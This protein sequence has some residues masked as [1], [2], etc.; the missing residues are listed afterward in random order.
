MVENNRHQ[1]LIIHLD[2]DDRPPRR[3]E[4]RV[5]VEFQLMQKLR[6]RN[7]LTETQD[8]HRFQNP[9]FLSSSHGGRTLHISK[10]FI[11][12]FF[13]FCLFTR[14]N[15]FLGRHDGQRQF[16][17]GIIAS[18]DARRQWRPSLSHEV[19]QSEPPFAQVSLIGQCIFI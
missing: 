14:F 11:S 3:K 8:C 1:N 10:R 9:N 4:R 12:I 19:S 2:K 16:F 13:F 18:T 6:E 5:R 7:S 15:G 17:M